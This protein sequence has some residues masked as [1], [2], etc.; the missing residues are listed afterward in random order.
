MLD[1]IQERVGSLILGSIT[2]TANGD[3]VAFNDLAS[4]DLMLVTVAGKIHSGGMSFNNT[5]GNNYVLSGGLGSFLGGSALVIG[6]GGGT[7]SGSLRRG[8]TRPEGV[9]LSLCFRAG[10]WRFG[11]SRRRSR[12]MKGNRNCGS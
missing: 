8:A 6:G 3:V 11:G 10:G 4:P 2:H 9:R 1:G 5:A 12:R 7:M